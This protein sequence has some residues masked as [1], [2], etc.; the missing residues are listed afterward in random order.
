MNHFSHKGR[1]QPKE[2][3]SN[4]AQRKLVSQP[5][6]S[7]GPSCRPYGS[8]GTAESPADSTLG[9]GKGI[10]A[11]IRMHSDDLRD[12][13]STSIRRV[14]ALSGASIDDHTLSPVRQ[15]RLL[16]CEL[17]Q[18]T[19]GSHSFPFVAYIFPAT[20]CR[21]WTSESLCQYRFDWKMR[22]RPRCRVTPVPILLDR[23][24][25]LFR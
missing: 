9:V 18:P 15:F 13:S 17:C 25:G 24:H 4:S 7:G 23:S 1:W 19:T 20:F 21:V 5:R 3:S 12:K 16:F 10:D 14:S 2:Q 8:Y 22:S 11:N 6:F